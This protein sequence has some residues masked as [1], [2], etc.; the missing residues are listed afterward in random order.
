MI[1][2]RHSLVVTSAGLVLFLLLAACG[3]TTPVPVVP[4][5]VPRTASVVPTRTLIP[6]PTPDPRLPTDTP[7]P[8]IPWPTM[9]Q[10]ALWEGGFVSAVAWF[11]DG[12]R[13]AATTAAG[14]LLA[15]GRTLAEVGALLLGQPVATVEFSRDGA[16][17]VLAVTDTVQLWSETGVGWQTRR[18]EGG[19]GKVFGLALTPDN[20]FLAAGEVSGTVRIWD[21]AQGAQ[22]QVWEAHEGEVFDVAFSPDARLLA[23]AGRDGFVR[24]W[25]VGTWE[26]AGSYQ[27]ADTVRG[28]DFSPDGRLLASASYDGAIGI[29]DVERGEQ[30]YA[31]RGHIAQVMCV[32]FSPDGELLAS[33]GMDGTVRVWDLATGN[34]VAWSEDHIDP[35]PGVAF[36]PDGARIASGGWDG[37]VRLWDV[38]VVSQ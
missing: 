5:S 36:S 30:V 14:V 4:T 33:G 13:L 23:S 11:P 27:H 29:W 2:M 1:R 35:V 32:D 3:P 9:P 21:P 38:G 37:T 20:A 34:I 12:Q 6:M 8:T 31:L 28:I 26:P 17:M 19:G 25:R 18:L 16:W 7:R 24:L 15:D 10:V 22:I